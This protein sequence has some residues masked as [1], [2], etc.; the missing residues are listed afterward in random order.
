MPLLSSQFKG[1]KQTVVTTTKQVIAGEGEGAAV[2]PA[3][4][5]RSAGLDVDS[6]DHVVAA[7]PALV[8]EVS[9]TVVEKTEKVVRT[10]TN[11]SE[12]NDGVEDSEDEGG[13]E[14]DAMFKAIASALGGDDGGDSDKAAGPKLF[15][16]NKDK[17]DLA[18]LLNVLDGVVDTPDRIVIM[19]TNHPE[20]LDAAL[21]RPGRID[22]KIYLGYLGYDSALQMIHHYFGLTENEM[23]GKHKEMIKK[24]F[25]DHK[26]I[27]PAVFEQYCSEHDTIQDFCEKAEEFFKI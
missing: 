1:P 20:K 4:S 8:R 22:K 17:L 7:P 5:P 11:Q 25:E 6:A 2:V 18:G 14:D 3:S 13:G 26:S 9:T 16:A 10:Q 12:A 19:T 21:I 24:V 23:E 15:S 27:T